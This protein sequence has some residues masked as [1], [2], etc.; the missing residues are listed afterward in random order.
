MGRVRAEARISQRDLGEEGG[1]PSSPLPF[2]RGPVSRL[3]G[4]SLVE[5]VVVIVIVATLAML[6]TNNLG[7]AGDDASEATTRSSMTTLRSA[8]LGFLTGTRRSPV[9]MTELFIRPVDDPDNPFDDD[10]ALALFDPAT[11][12]GWNGPYIATSTGSYTIDDDLNDP[13]NPKFRAV[14]G[15]N[16]DPACL[17]GWGKPIVVQIPNISELTLSASESDQKHV[18]LVSAGPDGQIQTPLYDVEVDP[19][20]TLGAKFPTKDQC[21]DDLV[22]YLRVADLRPEL[23]P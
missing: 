5:M 8:A 19:A 10:L 16:D 20:T 14:Y 9:Q 22:L 23:V 3:G 15:D 6:V 7:S 21:G 17:D 2:V 11:A 4:F 18:R 12:L 13:E 1:W